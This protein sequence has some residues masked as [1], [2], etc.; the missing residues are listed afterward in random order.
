MFHQMAIQNVRDMKAFD[1]NRKKQVWH[2]NRLRVRKSKTPRSYQTA[3]ATAKHFYIFLRLK[4]TPQPRIFLQERRDVHQSGGA[5]P[6]AHHAVPAV[7][8]SR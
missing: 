5:G 4:H 6:E 3:H 8:Q 7:H 2:W 1:S